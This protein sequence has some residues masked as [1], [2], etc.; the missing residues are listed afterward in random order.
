MLDPTDSA[1]LL[2]LDADPRAPVVELAARLGLARKTVQARLTRLEERPVLR[3]HSDRVP[4]TELG[5]DVAALVTI[6]VAQAQ[7]EAA[8]DGL[9]AIPEVLEAQA[10][11]GDGDIIC[12]VV[13]HDSRDLYRV[14]Q[15]ILRCPG[16]RRTS[17]VVLMKDL[18]P[19][20]TV[21]LLQHHVRKHGE[22]GATRRPPIDPTAAR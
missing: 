14:G 5:Y 12:R 11:T 8:V 21:P 9:R 13:A 10:T 16:I 7:L 22:E 6:Q 19:Y 18:V 15:L 4:P 2:A 20:R 1:I 17:T 3:P